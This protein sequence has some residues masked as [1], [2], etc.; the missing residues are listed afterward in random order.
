MGSIKNEINTDGTIHTGRDGHHHDARTA[1][2]PRASTAAIT[3]DCGW[4]SRGP[5]TAGECQ[6]W[7]N[8]IGE[9]MYEACA[10]SPGKGAPPARLRRRART[11]AR[12]VELG[13]GAACRSRS[14]GQPVRAWRRAAAKP[15]ETVISD[16]NPSYDSDKLPGTAFGSVTRRDMGGLESRRSARRC[17]TNEIGRQPKYY[18][19]QSLSDATM[20]TRRRQRP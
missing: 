4:K 18:I 1:S 13:G 10:I 9:M 3:Y 16:I 7:G 14:L 15:F 8:P 11:P 5:I 20:T 2:R 12:K 6:M 19:G 17:G